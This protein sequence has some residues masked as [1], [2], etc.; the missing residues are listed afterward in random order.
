MELKKVDYRACKISSTKG[1]KQSSLNKNADTGMRLRIQ[2]L[3]QMLHKKYIFTTKYGFPM[4]II[5]FSEK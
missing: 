1:I 3:R 2:I 5:Q 4:T